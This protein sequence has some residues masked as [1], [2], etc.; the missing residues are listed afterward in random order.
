MR[1]NGK[2][3]NLDE[4]RKSRSG[5]KKTVSPLQGLT[6]RDIEKTTIVSIG[7]G[8]KTL[9]TEAQF[10]RNVAK[11]LK[12]LPK[13]YV[14]KIQQMG[15]VGDPDYICVING[16]PVYLELKRSASHKA[17]PLQVRTLEQAK[18]S[19]AYAKVVHPENWGAVSSY[20]EFLSTH[21]QRDIIGES[22]HVTDEV[23]I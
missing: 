13:T 10:Q 12:D 16:W 8:G 4:A 21:S 18:A 14:T 3:I 23:I 5:Y 11:F 1:K 7:Q 20:L 2:L 6:P 22:Y 19:G 9:R 15:R 17:R